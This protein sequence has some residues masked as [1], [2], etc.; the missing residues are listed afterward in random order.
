MR[1]N[2][3]SGKDSPRRTIPFVLCA[4]ALAMAA[5]FFSCNSDDLNDSSHKGTLRLNLAADTTG[6]KGGAL[7]TKATGEF[8][9]FL[10]I[11]SYTV[12]VYSDED[13]VESLLYKDFPEEIEIKEGSY[14]LKA[15][16]G[17]NIPAAFDNPYFEGSKEFTVK[18]DMKTPLEVIC[19]MANARVKAAYSEDFLKAYTDYSVMLKTSHLSSPFEIPQD[20]QRFAYLEVDKEGSPLVVAISLKRKNWAEAKVYTVTDPSI[21]LKPKE[22]I[23]L[24]FSTD[25]KTGDGLALSVVLD[26][27]LTEAE[28]RDTIPDF[29]WKP[30]EKP[31]LLPQDFK[32]NDHI[33]ISSAG[34]NVPPTLAF[35]VPSGI[36]NFN[37]WRTVVGTSDTIKYDIATTQGA[38]DAKAVGFSWGGVNLNGYRKNGQL[39]LENAFKQLEY[40]GA[41]KEYEFIFFAKDNL[42]I[43]NYTETIHFFVQKVYA[44]PTIKLNT[45]LPVDGV[46]EGEA[47]KNDIVAT[48]QAEGGIK[49]VI[50]S[51]KD[52]AGVGIKYTKDQLTAL[53]ASLSLDV[54]GVDGVLTIPKAF[55]EKLNAL[56]DADQNYT[57][58]I[59]VDAKEG[60]EANL[61]TTSTNP[62]LIKCPKYPLAMAPN[63]GDV[64]AKRAVLKANLTVGLPEK[65]KFQKKEGNSWVDVPAI[66]RVKEGFMQVD[67]LKG[68]N[69][70]TVYA[71]RVVYANGH[72]RVSEVYE[73]TTEVAAPIINGGMED[74]HIVQTKK[75]SIISFITYYC[76]Y[77]Y[78]KGASGWWTTNNSRSMD[79]VV[80]PVSATTC[81]AVSYVKDAYGGNR[82]AEI[83]TTAGS[84]YAHTSD[85]MYEDGIIRGML[86]VGDYK[87]DGSTE[88]LMPGRPF[89]TRPQKL[90]F[91]YK[92]APYNT[93][94]FEAYIEIQNKNGDKITK[95]G[96]ATFLKSSSTSDNEYQ[97]SIVPIMYN[98]V[99]LKATHIY[100]R[101]VSTTKDK[102]EAKKKSSV[103]LA[104]AT[105][106]WTA[107][108]GSCLKID[109]VEL[110]Y[111]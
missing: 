43:T 96:S 72:D 97:N 65:L 93:D 21:T 62:L 81:P 102:P 49:E 14:T 39:H 27:Q 57:L 86:L 52:A 48:L 8:D 44:A 82:A 59:T 110:I 75:W 33:Q 109:D 60:I 37:V 92:Y 106:G 100:V 42:P 15:F 58:D 80:T 85:V 104:D 5:S 55:T 68:L 38:T 6:I 34:L 35:G 12:Q 10:D 103:D 70:V 40:I 77:P 89:Q 4:L 32:N 11:N 98:D 30:F 91:W 88:S 61:S 17:T 51:I 31:T 16:K 46:I 23:T 2:E 20:E 66:D 29:M 25:G 26:D 108:I 76:Y 22:S 47:L 74:W 111:E 64:F 63:E 54:N 94:E 78:T 83:R 28:L 45:P 19:T 18:E 1:R 24:N 3:L 69:P 79:W 67:T 107:H 71:V 105:N 90:S 73:F 99:T 84:G 101:F 95:L 13:T 41:D 87:W 9:N 36:A 7:T 56:A 53:G 50:V